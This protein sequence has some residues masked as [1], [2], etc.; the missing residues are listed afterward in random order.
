VSRRGPEGL[1]DMF[2]HWRNYVS[3]FAPARLGVRVSDIDNDL[4]SYFGVKEGE[5]VLV[6]DV[7]DASTA[8]AIGVKSGDVITGV[9][10]KSVESAEDIRA[11]L[12]DTN[13]GDEVY[14][15]VVR[16]EKKVE[17]KGEMQEGDYRAWQHVWERRGPTPPAVAPGYDQELR[18]EI[19]ELRK[20]IQQL[21]E[22]L[23]EGLKKS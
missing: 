14:V 1:G 13:P 16:N 9:Q 7:D 8:E 3:A 5:G 6:L 19:D 2:P 4:G 17:L 23:K 22:E 15:T 10:G 11:S 12:S 21:K 18:K 20:E